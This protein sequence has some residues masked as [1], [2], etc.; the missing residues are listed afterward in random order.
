MSKQEKIE[1]VVAMSDKIYEE[2]S[3]KDGQWSEK[4]GADL[5]YTTAPEHLSKE[6]L[7][8]ARDHRDVFIAGSIH[9]AGRAAIEAMTADA[10]CKLVTGQI[11]LGGKDHL[12]VTAERD[13]SFPVP[14]KNGETITKPLHIS[15]KLHVEGVRNVGSVSKVHDTLSELAESA[16]K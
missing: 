1:Q 11:S 3:V 2:I 14:G 9:A 10:N 7:D 4:E 5:F 15:Q 12:A 16:F 13:K 8:D 6:I